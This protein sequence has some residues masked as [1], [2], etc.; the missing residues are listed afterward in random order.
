MV[1]PSLDV[2]SEELM[3]VPFGAIEET[4]GSQCYCLNHLHHLLS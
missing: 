2:A 4:F 1:I 3:D